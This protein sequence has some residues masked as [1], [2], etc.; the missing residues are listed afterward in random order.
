MILQSAIPYGHVNLLTRWASLIEDNWI[1]IVL[2][3]ICVIVVLD[4]WINGGTTI[5]YD[6]THS[7]DG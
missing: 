1:L 3:I 5:N 7:I 2:G 4:A 6:G